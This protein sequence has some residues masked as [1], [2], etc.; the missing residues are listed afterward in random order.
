MLE[1]LHRVLAAGAACQLAR[2]AE[3]E[4]NYS[5]MKS[6]PSCAVPARRQEYLAGRSY[7][8]EAMARLA[9][10]PSAILTVRVGAAH[11]CA[12]SPYRPS[13]VRELVGLETNRRTACRS[14]VIN[15]SWHDR[16]GQHCG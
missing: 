14:G 1:Y 7:A 12:S 3:Q 8:R 13:D 9:L 5:R 4:E 2:S 6:K 16:N 10:P 11:Y 15:R